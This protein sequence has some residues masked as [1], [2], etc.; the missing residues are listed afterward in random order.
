MTYSYRISNKYFHVNVPFVMGIYPSFA[1][2]SITGKPSH[3]LDIV[4]DLL[5]IMAA[6]SRMLLTHFDKVSYLPTDFLKNRT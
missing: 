4:Y 5:L 2:S 1:I 3:H 6:R